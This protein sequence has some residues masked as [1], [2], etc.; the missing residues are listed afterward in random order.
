[1]NFKKLSTQNFLMIFIAVIIPTLSIGGLW[2][3]DI[4]SK[5]HKDFI[6][7]KHNYI[8]SQ[9]N[10]LKTQVDNIKNNIENIINI[11]KTKTNNSLDTKELQYII[12]NQLRAYRFGKDDYI[13]VYNTKGVNIMH[14]VKPQ[15]EGKNLINL[16]DKNGKYLIRELIKASTSKTNHFVEYLWQQP[17]T[18]KIAK[19]LG[20]AQ[21]I[22]QWN[23]MIGSGLYMNSIDAVL[24]AKY[25]KLQDSV[26][27]KIIQVIS[28]FCFILLIIFYFVYRR[29]DKTNSS[30]LLFHNF[31]EHAHSTSDLINIDKIEYVE[32][33][34]LA[35]D[36]NN[37]LIKRSKILAELDSKNAQLLQQSRLAQMGEMISMIAHQWRQPLSAINAVSGNLTLKAK[38]DKLDNDTV[39]ELGEKI[40]DYSQHLSST[41]DDFR[42]FFK[43]NKEKREAAFNDLI[44]NVLNIVED[45][46][47]NQNI[48]LIT[49]LNS[50]NTFNTYPNEI[51]Q[52]ILN[53]I[54]NAEDILLEKK[55]ENPCI[56]IKTY[57][58][59]N[60]S[61][62]SVEDN[63]GGIPK[64]IIDKIFDP[65]F[66]TKTKKNGTGLGLY[67]SKTIIEEHCNGK[68]IASNSDTGAKFTIIL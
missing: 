68:L 25:T 20:Y 36:A 30:F 60:N 27:S 45:S 3:S 64:D 8:T 66:S 23:W 28:L 6:T 2:L 34:Q 29:I 63:G 37:M 1:M 18:N 47:I 65:Y 14:P 10:I 40:S 55:I 11:Y 46:I 9:K 54:K 19:K 16:K 39:I 67:M 24:K 56:K 7:L 51:K 41:I 5:S 43:P 22:P 33:K 62:L 38:L 21:N 48:E 13:F 35:K 61:Y 57:D 53:L 15:L 58:D 17:S 31:L 26:R 32:F 42:D 49:E 59:E 4:Y 50:K 12:L 44:K 52:V